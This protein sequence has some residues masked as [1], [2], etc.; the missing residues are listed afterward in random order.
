VQRSTLLISER[1]SSLYTT[2]RAC[3]AKLC[4]KSRLLSLT[5]SLRFSSWESVFRMPTQVLHPSLPHS[6]AV[7][8]RSRATSHD[9]TLVPSSEGEENRSTPKKR[10]ETVRKRKP[11]F[12]LGEVIEISSDDDSPAPSIPS[13]IVTDLRRQVK[14]LKEVI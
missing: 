10:K 14:K 4:S 12:P 11:L 3:Q 5:T 1:L 7:R 8:Q 6:I 2:R 9:L 13:S